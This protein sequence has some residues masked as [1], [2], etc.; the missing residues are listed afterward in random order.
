MLQSGAGAGVALAL[1][2][3]FGPPKDPTIRV[4]DQ[5]LPTS[6]IREFRRKQSLSFK[7]Q[8][9]KHRLD[10]F[11][12]L[13]KDLNPKKSWNPLAQDSIPPLLT[14]LGSDWLSQARDLNLLQPLDPGSF[15]EGW[16]QVPPRWQRAIEAYGSE[17]W[18]IPWRWGMTAIAYNSRKLS[19]PIENWSDLWRPELTRKLTLLDHP[20][21]V[22]GLTLKKLG[23]S[24]NDP[25]QER[26]EI[27][28]SELKALHQQALTYT[29]QSYIQML[30]IEDS[31][32]A[33]G[34][35]EDLF[36]LA[37][38][39]P[40]FKVVI[41]K[42][43]TAIWWDLWVTPRPPEDHKDLWQ[44]WQELIPAWFNFVLDPKI[45]SRVVNLSQLASIYSAPDLSSQLKN[46]VDFT[47]NA[48]EQSEIWDPLSP[49]QAK[50]YLTLWQTMHMH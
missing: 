49:E 22:I 35:T 43:G 29:S 13:Q 7:L 30:Q 2:G 38:N 34:W 37:Q 39:F 18:G 5:V 25:L 41:P 20:R 16:N 6:L 9:A 12:Q 48:A 17:L 3:C 26:E 40:H 45:A 27:L 14:L 47:S 36:H 31:W 4:L 24:Y 32:V 42:S 19:F 28:I 50:R 21:E 44:N 33:V 1:A 23:R 10:L 11:E 46:R 8:P 15:Q